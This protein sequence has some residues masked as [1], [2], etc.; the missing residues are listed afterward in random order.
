MK[1]VAVLLVALAACDARQSIEDAECPPEG[2]E[3]TYENFG[4]QYLSR[5]CNY[6]HG[7]DVEER[8][9]APGGYTFDD[10]D[11][12][13]DQIDRIY[14]RS[15]GENTSMPPGPDDPSEEDRYALEEWLACG[16]P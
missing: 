8:R 6:C 10:H 15:A 13:L 7:E 1:R 11:S 2:T 3:L 4:R 9:G 16:A 12:V 5:H 14:A